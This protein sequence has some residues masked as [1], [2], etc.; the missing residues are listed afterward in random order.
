MVLMKPNTEQWVIGG[1]L[2][3][4]VITLLVLVWMRER[5]PEPRPVETTPEAVVEPEPAGPQYPIEEV[6]VPDSVAGG[7]LVPLP[8]LDDSDAYFALALGDVFGG[9]LTDLL[10]DEALIEKVVTTIDNLPRA[11]LAER[12][13]PLEGTPGSFA[14]EA[15]P[16]AERFRPAAQNYARYDALVSMFTTPSADSLVATYRRFYPLLQEAYINQG[17]PDGYFNDRVV[18]VVDHLLETPIPPEAATLVRPH[19]LYEYADEE[20]ESL[21]SG[22]KLLL[23][24]GPEH[25]EAVKARL[26]EIRP[27]IA[28]DGPTDSPATTETEDP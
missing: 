8:P 23:R 11:K 6:Q 25:A 15:G 5:S 27:M 18:E 7:R 14:V 26:A 2:T 28:V 13:R 19:V 16:D 21:S 12:L 20:L 17:Y 22:Q 10:A 24:M 3:I 1:L 4:S 9:N